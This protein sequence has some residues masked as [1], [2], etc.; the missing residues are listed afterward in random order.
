MFPLVDEYVVPLAKAEKTKG[1]VDKVMGGNLLDIPLAKVS[2]ELR[3]ERNRNQE[4]TEENEEIKAENKEIKAE[5]NEVKAKNAAYLDRI[6]ELERD[7]ALLREAKM[8]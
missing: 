7:L 6:K 5:M 4:I 8:A 3:L 1:K 2:H